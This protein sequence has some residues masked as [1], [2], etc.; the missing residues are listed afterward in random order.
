M[1][2]TRRNLIQNRY[3]FK[4]LTHWSVALAGSNAEKNEGRKYRWAVPLKRKL[5]FFFK[6]IGIELIL[7][8][9]FVNFRYRYLN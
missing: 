9:Y 1:Q 6:A 8:L 2:I 4:F 7:L 5:M 3:Y